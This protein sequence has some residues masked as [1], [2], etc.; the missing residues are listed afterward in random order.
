MEYYRSM[1][2][3]GA[4][5]AAVIEDVDFPNCIAAGGVR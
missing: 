2:F 3:G 4:P 5:T 1:A